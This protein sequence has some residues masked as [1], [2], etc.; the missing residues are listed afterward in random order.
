MHERELERKHGDNRATADDFATPG[1]ANASGALA[2]SERASASGILMRKG[3]GAS[4]NADVAQSIA[5]TSTGTQLPEELREKFEGSLGTDL[6]SVRVHTGGASETAASA[7]SARAFAIGQDV[8][9]GA[10][11]YDPASES[12]QHLIAHEVAHT[13]QQRGGTPVQQNKLAV[14]HA[15]DALEVEADRAADAMV[16]GRPA[17]VSGGGLAISR[18]PGLQHAPPPPPGMVTL[19]TLGPVAA[20][21]RAGDADGSGSIPSPAGLY[22]KAESNYNNS[23]NHCTNVQAHYAAKGTGVELPLIGDALAPGNHNFKKFAK[24]AGEANAYC[25][26]GA[27]LANGASV[28]IGMWVPLLQNSQS[29]WAEVKKAADKAGIDTVTDEDGSTSLEAEGVEEEGTV[30]KGRDH[31]V[32]PKDPGELPPNATP[33][34]K[35]DHQRRKESSDKDGLD[36]KNISPQAKTTMNNATQLFDISM[37]DVTTS[38]KSVVLKHGTARKSLLDAKSKANAKRQSTA[39]GEKAGIEEILG[40]VDKAYAAVEKGRSVAS[41]V[42]SFVDGSGTTAE[43]GKQAGAVEEKVGSTIS[44]ITPGAVAK[45]ILQLDGTIPGIEGE[46]AACKTRDENL[47]GVI[48]D[49]AIQSAGGEFV[50]ALKDF[51]AALEKLKTEVT[52]YEAAHKAYAEAVNQA[53]MKR[54]LLKPG[55]DGVKPIMDVLAKV[56]IASSSTAAAIAATADVL[57]AVNAMNGLGAPPQPDVCQLSKMAAAHTKAFGTAPSHVT[58]ISGVLTKREAKLK[59]YVAKLGI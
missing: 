13:V 58:A 18:S 33:Q 3:E 43:Q 44:G 19:K 32:N 56:R 4:E 12:G 21:V 40:M 27:V 53:M 2:R 15:G 6:S 47:K 41:S 49:G 29:C 1:R 14:S 28:A 23:A 20:A 45:A 35:A 25:E 26:S 51:K 52:N 11:Q 31:L 37:K 42:G 17:S 24:T 46:I 50:Q 48:D 5:S 10:G 9:F 39:E 57:V 36:G 22:D 34:Q 59:S 30:L 55:D 54:G 38:R 7:V 8:H 16:S